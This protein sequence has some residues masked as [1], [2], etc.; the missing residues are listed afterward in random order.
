MVEGRDIDSPKP[1]GEIQSLTERL[2]RF[3]GRLEIAVD[4]LEK[5]VSPALASDVAVT[6]ETKDEK[7][8]NTLIGKNLMGVLE[9]G[10]N[11]LDRIQTLNRRLSI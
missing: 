9:S 1:I 8:P 6:S 5:N 7:T 3:M 10:E 4:E 11:Q 2:L